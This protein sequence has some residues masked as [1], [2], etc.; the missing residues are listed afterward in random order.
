MSYDECIIVEDSS[1]HACLGLKKLILFDAIQLQYGLCLFRHPPIPA[2][3]PQ[4]QVPPHQHHRRI[5]HLSFNPRSAPPVSATPFLPSCVC[6]CHILLREVSLRQFRTV[7][8]KQ[9]V[10]IVTI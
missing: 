4:Q 8:K 10:S 5:H 1:F 3:S 6:V 9:I 2:D 7:L